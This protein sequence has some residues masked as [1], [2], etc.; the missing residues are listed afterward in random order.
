[1]FREE[2]AMSL[3]HNTVF[4]Y[5]FEYLKSLR[6]LKSVTSQTVTGPVCVFS[7]EKS[8]YWRVVVWDVGHLICWKSGVFK[9]QGVLK[10]RGRNKFPHAAE[11]GN[12][13]WMEQ[14]LYLM[15]PIEFRFSSHCF[16]RS[17]ASSK[18]QNWQWQLHLRQNWREM[19]GWYNKLP[20]VRNL[21]FIWPI[22]RDGSSI[23][24]SEDAC[25]LRSMR[26]CVFVCLWVNLMC[27]IS[28]TTFSG[29]KKGAFNLGRLWNFYI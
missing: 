15:R 9:V 26:M 1:M 4:Q 27:F 11:E 22:V 3:V 25:F 14:Y 28:S 2:G 12:L 21:F 24:L 7:L 8:D 19:K 6:L 18:L 17:S 20:G 23:C 29:S 13:T 5:W 10:I 16:S